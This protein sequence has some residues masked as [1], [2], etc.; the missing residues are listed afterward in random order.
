MIYL[1][2]LFFSSF[3][4]DLLK[5][6]NEQRQISE[7]LEQKRHD[8]FNRKFQKKMK[9]K[10]HAE[11][12]DKLAKKF[13]ESLPDI[14]KIEE[15]YYQNAV[16]DFANKWNVQQNKRKQ[17]IEQLKHE[18][19]TDHINEVQTIKQNEQKFQH[20]HEMEKVKRQQNEKIDLI[21][22]HQKYA[23][24]IQ[25][26]K[27]LRQIIN[28]QIEMNE[29]VRQHEHITSRIE[30]NHAIES[31]IQQDDKHFFDYANKLINAAKCKGIPIHPLK[32]VIDEYTRKNALLQQNDD[33]PHMKSQ[34]DIGIS[35]E[36][37]YAIQ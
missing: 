34:I 17:H 30:T 21:F 11:Y 14:E 33:L 16:R 26:A 37:K 19:I 8:E 10:Q 28:K 13:F 23:D 5:L 15:K 12:R 35:V 25:K 3:S 7:Y 18:R 4:E 31:A 2:C 20:E 36:R 32:K 27:Q 24:R 29:Q 9:Q 1:F 22:Y 6:K